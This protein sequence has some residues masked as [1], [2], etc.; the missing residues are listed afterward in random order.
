MIRLGALLHTKAWKPQVSTCDP[1]RQVCAAQIPIPIRKATATRTASSSRRRPHV[2]ESESVVFTTLK[3]VSD[4]Y[5]RYKSLF[6]ILSKTNDVETVK[7]CQDISPS[8]CPVF[9]C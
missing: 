8:N 7:A 1:Q 2:S 3:E 9:S 4:S 6:T 5:Q